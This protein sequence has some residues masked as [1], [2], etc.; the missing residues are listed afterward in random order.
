MAT[1]NSNP[2]PRRITDLT[3]K[4][5]GFQVVT[6]FAETRKKQQY[7]N[8]R[9]DCGY[10][11][12]VIA[13]N[14]V[15]GRST[16]CSTNCPANPVRA[17][18]TGNVYGQ[19]TVLKYVGTNGASD[20]MWLCQCDCGNTTTV[21]RGD[22]R[23]KY[24][25]THSCGCGRKTQGGGYKTP[26]YASWKEMKRRCYNPRY[27][28]YHLYGG[29]GITICDR[30]RTSFVNFLADMGKRPFP[31]ASIDRINNA[32]NY[33][34]GNCRW[35]T[36]LE[37][38]QNTRKVRLLTFNGETMCLR[39]WARRIGITKRTLSVRL[40]RGWPLDKALTTPRNE[41]C[42]AHIHRLS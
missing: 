40:E 18:E 7:W 4:R 11:R 24:G 1:S 21:A 19:L 37:Q 34:P 16:R 9:C 25:G 36:R 6:S 28:E 32:G 3:G 39:A 23:K 5:F 15:S 35:S 17:D 26:E 38:G 33:E 10:E 30:W 8:V 29:R 14:L 12:P 2:V 22:L 42:I 41:S 20:S 13:S 31:E 27:R